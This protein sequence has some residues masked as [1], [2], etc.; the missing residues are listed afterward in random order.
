MF[1]FIFGTACLAGLFYTLRGGP[2]RHHPHHG[3]G[4][5]RR[6]WRGRMRWVFE[7]LDTSP[8]QEKVFVKAADDLNEA[9]EKLR[10]ELGAT[11]AAIARALREEQFDAAGMRELN[12]RHDALIENLRQTVRASLS[13]LHEALDP[14]QRRELADLIEHGWGYG[15]RSY[16]G[17]CGGG[18]RGGGYRCA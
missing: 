17:R 9:F 11:R 7:R 18:W 14:R 15:Y 10:D 4:G 16:G 8:G 3:R 5:G 1:G 12:E 13:Q 2:W 6:G